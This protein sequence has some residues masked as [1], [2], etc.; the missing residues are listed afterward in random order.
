MTLPLPTEDQKTMM[1]NHALALTEGFHSVQHAVTA[2]QNTS[3]NDLTPE[4]WARI[5]QH[6]EVWTPMSEYFLEALKPFAA[7]IDDP[8]MMDALMPHIT[9]ALEAQGLELE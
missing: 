1:I 6:M 8:A 5:V 4:A 7:I 2:I 3:F 9:T